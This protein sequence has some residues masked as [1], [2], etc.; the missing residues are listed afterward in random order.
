M[1]GLAYMGY[2]KTIQ[3]TRL[4][5]S[6]EIYA[7]VVGV[8]S[9]N[10]PMENWRLLFRQGI[11]KGTDGILRLSTKSSNSLTLADIQQ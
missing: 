1:D 10:Y 5:T 7:A 4:P 9:P 3:L 8:F 11:G 2:C 6:A